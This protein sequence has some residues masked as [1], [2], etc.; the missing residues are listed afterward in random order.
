MTLD[1]VRLGRCCRCGNCCRAT[2]IFKSLTDA[3]RAIIR[4]ADP[5]AEVVLNKDNVGC[6]HLIENADGT[7]SCDIYIKRP[8]F[9]RLYP[10]VPDDL[11]EGCSFKFIIAQTRRKKQ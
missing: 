7:T 3:E 4:M 11:V 10:L 9:C 6:P 1:F 5:N 2:P 8:R